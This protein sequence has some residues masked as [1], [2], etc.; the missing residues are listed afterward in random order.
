MLSY[1]SV[2]PESRLKIF[3]VA[4]FRRDD[5]VVAELNLDFSFF[6]KATPLFRGSDIDSRSLARL[7]I[8]INHR[9]EELGDRK[10]PFA[11]NE[12]RALTA[13]ASFTGTPRGRKEE[14]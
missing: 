7:T 10:P 1:L 14:G 6:F 9:R 2:Q 4:L 5:V 13:L 8:I 11:T 3:P 12:C